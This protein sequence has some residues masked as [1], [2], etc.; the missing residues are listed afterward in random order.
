MS[1]STTTTAAQA[2]LKDTAKLR[3]DMETLLTI[4]RTLAAPVEGAPDGFMQT[5][6]ILLKAVVT[7]VEETQESVAELHR[8]LEEPG[9]AAVL[10]RLMEAE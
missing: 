2:I 6:V 8:R 9:I 7:R 5:V 4:A 10:R 1:A 3:T